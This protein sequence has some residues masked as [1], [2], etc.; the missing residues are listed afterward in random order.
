MP[1]QWLAQQGP[2]PDTPE[3]T[4]DEDP[5]AAEE[6]GDSSPKVESEA[7]LSSE[8]DNEHRAME[9]G[10]QD[11]GDSPP[12]HSEAART[13]DLSPARSWSSGT[14]SLGPPSDSPS[15]HWDGQPPG[16]LPVA[17]ADSPR[18]PHHLL[19]PADSV[20]GS[21]TL[22]TTQEF[23]D[24]STPP[25][26]GPPDPAERWG[27]QPTGLSC[28]QRGAQA[29]KRTWTSPKALPSRFTGSISTPRSRPARLDRPSP[30]PEATLAGHAASNDARKYGRGQLNHP[31][32]DLSKVGPRV[33]F[34]KDESYRPP[35][36]RNPGRG[37]QDPARPLVFKSPA[38]IVREVL[39]RSEEVCPAQTLPPTHPIARV[40]QEFQTPEQAT[41]LVHQLQ[42]SRTRF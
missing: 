35:K 31:L 17:P 38:E 15:P 32:P 22:A 18:R 37:P 24:S 3:A 39:L 13:A 41:K 2:C 36:A 11:S 14:V 40:P 19:K 27:P 1:A 7:G 12:E 9:W 23:Q 33:R 34:P 21:V 25:S 16:P 20:G 29:W 5:G 28:P 4:P 30:R 42:V 10:P 26:S 6:T 8:E